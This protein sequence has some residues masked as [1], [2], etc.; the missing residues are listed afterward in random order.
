MVAAA[1]NLTRR[2]WRALVAVDTG[3]ARE[4]AQALLARV[5]IAD[6]AGMIARRAPLGYLKR[7]QVARALALRPRLLLLDEPLAG[8]NY[9]EAAR[10]ADLIAELNADGVTIVLIEH[11]LGEVTRTARRLVVLHNGA[12]LAE[13]APRDVMERQDVRDAYLGAGAAHA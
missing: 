2:P 5:G 12:V 7:M 9:A 8:L 4:R 11:N 1:A 6:A 10:F 13:G 3:P